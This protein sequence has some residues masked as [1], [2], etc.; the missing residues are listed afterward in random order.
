[1][2]SFPDDHGP[3]AAAARQL[4]E[5]RVPHETHVLKGSCRPQICDPADPHET[6][7]FDLS[8]DEL[9]EARSP[10][11]PSWPTIMQTAQRP[12]STLAIF[13]A[14]F[15]VVGHALAE[16]TGQRRGRRST[17]QE[18]PDRRAGSRADRR[19][20]AHD[21][22]RAAR[23][24]RP[25][26]QPCR[27]AVR[28]RPRASPGR[29]ASTARVRPADHRRVRARQRHRR[30]ASMDGRVRRTRAVRC[31]PVHASMPRRP[32]PTRK[33]H[34][35]GLAGR[36]RASSRRWL[37]A[38][39]SGPAARSARSSSGLRASVGHARFRFETER[40]RPGDPQGRIDRQCPCDRA[41]DGVRVVAIGGRRSLHRGGARIE[42][43]ES[44][45]CL[46]ERGRA[47]TASSASSASR[48]ARNTSPGAGEPSPAR[49][50][51][52]GRRPRPPA[53]RRH[54]R[55]ARRR[56]R[57]RSQPAS[58]PRGCRSAVPCTGQ[59]RCGRLERQRGDARGV[60][61]RLLPR[62]ARRSEPTAVADVLE[63]GPVV[64]Q[65]LRGRE[66]VA[67]GGP[68]RRDRD[69]VGR[70]EAGFVERASGV[71]GRRLEASVEVLG[72]R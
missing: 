25:A 4:D 41:C 14:A 45:R 56:R 69:V 23:R 61:P 15:R 53:K 31:R 10:S 12:R 65:E 26:A 20:R 55:I 50:R 57:A 40:V 18:A 2:S 21:G 34:P 48:R 7:A 46:R 54:P 37:R 24:S 51:R 27:S 63:E 22:H 11:P 70:R 60:S 59:L 44:P 36:R 68:A 16:R 17:N 1:M 8:T 29:H 72:S 32:R 43:D 67:H 35:E 19:P 66:G 3:R 9:R 38:P 42:A 58:A 52:P 49:A 5:L 30:R 62:N 64:R 13:L 47:R 71:L 6:I 33:R 28:A 39:S